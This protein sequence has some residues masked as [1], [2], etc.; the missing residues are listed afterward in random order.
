MLKIFS[1][2]G[3]SMRKA[4]PAGQCVFSG[5]MLDHPALERMTERELGD[6]PFPRVLAICR[7]DENAKPGTIPD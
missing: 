6:L 1:I 3:T 7:A 2:L 5:D 4:E